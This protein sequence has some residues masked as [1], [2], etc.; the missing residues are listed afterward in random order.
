MP[1]TD[2]T[3]GTLD[4]NTSGM[5]RGIENAILACASKEPCGV[6]K[7]AL[8]TKCQPWV[9]MSITAWSIRQP[10]PPLWQLTRDCSCREW[11]GSIQELHIIT[12][13]QDITETI[14]LT[15]IAL[16]NGPYFL[17]TTAVQPIQASN[18]YIVPAHSLPV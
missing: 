9:D 4:Q 5:G 18:L 8:V 1:C 7:P 12:M 2:T 16:I 3:T 13:L 10:M 6:S 15:T 14:L 17:S 11:A